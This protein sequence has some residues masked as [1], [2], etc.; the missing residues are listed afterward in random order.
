MGLSRQE[1]FRYWGFAGLTLAV[2]VWIMGSA[3]LPFVLG[4]AIAYLLDPAAD[5]LERHRV[6]RLLATAIVTSMMVMVMAVIMFLVIPLLI[7]QL[8]ALISASPSAFESIKSVLNERYPG[9]FEED[10]SVRRAVDAMQDSWKSGAASLIEGVLSSSLVLIDILIVLVL[11]PVV[12]FYLLMDWDRMVA[13]IDELIP[14]EHLD[15]VRKLASEFDRV[16]GGFV[17]G[18][19]SVCAILGIFYAIGLSIVG[20]NFG[21][22]VGALA[23]LITFIP[24]VGSIVGGILAVGLAVIQFWGDPAWIAVVAAIFIVGQLVEGNF[25]TPY[26]VGG[27]VGLHPVWL[28]FALSAFGAFFGFTGLLIAVPAAAVVGVLTRYLIDQY[29]SGRLYLGSQDDQDAA[30]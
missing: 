14:R 18:Q 27:S 5:W 16:L 11:A 20:L 29:Q 22:L 13:K 15:T 21:V 30:E 12:S 3:L 7:E 1:Q 28:M 25:L 24:F 2:F 26:L 10:S 19:L 4:M 17:R 9:I 23:G 6:S 8:R